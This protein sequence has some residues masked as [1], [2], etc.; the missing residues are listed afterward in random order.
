M[1]TAVGS[2]AGAAGVSGVL[3][4]GM[5]GGGISSVPS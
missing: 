4:S 2:G 1:T 3:G 5:G